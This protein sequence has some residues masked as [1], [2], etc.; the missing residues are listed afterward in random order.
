YAP[1]EVQVLHAEA[2]KINAYNVHVLLEEIECF[3]PDVAYAWMLVGVGG[4][5]LM[6]CLEHLRVPWV[7]HLMDA[8]PVH[9]CEMMG[10]VP[11]ALAKA[12]Q[13]GLPGHYITCSSRVVEEIESGGIHLNGPVELLPNWVVGPHPARRAGYLEGGQLR[14]VTAGQVSRHKGVDL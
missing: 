3:Q 7:W 6:A 4:L 1:V 5:G 10:R 11:P 2:N 13:R 8:V 9:L 14:I 12:F